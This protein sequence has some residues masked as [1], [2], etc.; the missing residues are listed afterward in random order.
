M[1]VEVEGRV[2]ALRDEAARLRSQAAV[3]ANQGL[4]WAAAVC[5][6]EADRNDEAVAVE[7][8]GIGA[9]VA[10]RERPVSLAVVELTPADPWTV[11]LWLPFVALVTLLVIAAGLGWLV[12]HI[13]HGGL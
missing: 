1:S 4:P 9:P 10:V 7:T 2:Q 6:Y 8:A 12:A 3:F 5:W 11:P 13:A